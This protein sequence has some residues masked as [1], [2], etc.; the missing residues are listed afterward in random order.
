MVTPRTERN[1]APSFLVP[2]LCLL[3]HVPRATGS[4]GIGV[5]PTRCPHGRGQR[6]ALVAPQDPGVGCSLR[7]NDVCGALFVQTPFPQPTS[8]RDAAR[9]PPMLC[10]RRFDRIGSQPRALPPC[11]GSEG[12]F[13]CPSHPPGPR[14]WLLLREERWTCAFFVR[15]LLLTH[16][17]QGCG[18]RSPHTVPPAA[19]PN[20]QPAPCAAPV[21]G[22]RGVPRCHDPARWLVPA[23]PLCVNISC[24]VPP[25]PLVPASSH[26]RSLSSSLFP[27]RHCASAPE[28]DGRQDASQTHPGLSRKTLRPRCRPT[29]G[30]PP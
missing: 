8:P 14:G 12:S 7:K 13:G 4:A 21:R 27:R 1:C 10:P 2:A 9:D 28:V 23:F 22:V 24:T 30:H 5:Q 20:R 29:L 25:H 15:P 16:I 26:P 11:A 3:Q 19:R 6:G 18:Q 17:P